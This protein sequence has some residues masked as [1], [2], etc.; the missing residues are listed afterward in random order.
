MKRNISIDKDANILLSKEFFTDNNIS[1]MP[2]P[3]NEILNIFLFFI[4]FML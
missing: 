3:N 4:L 1:A 2:I